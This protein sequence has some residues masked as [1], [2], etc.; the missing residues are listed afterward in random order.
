MPLH[1]TWMFLFLL[2]LL[3][4][5][6]RA[7]VVINEIFYH[8]PDDIEELAYIELHNTD[9]D[10]VD[11][12]GWEFTRGVKFKFPAGTEIDSGGF[13]VVCRNQARLKRFFGVT[14]AG[15]FES[16]LSAKG[17]RIELTDARG[18]KVDAVKYSDEAP[19]PLG[20]DGLSGS[21]ERITPEGGSDNPVNWAAS[22]LSAD[23][24]KPTGTPGR[25]NSCFSAEMPPVVSAVKAQPEHPAPNQPLAVDATVR[26]P[27]GVGSVKLLYLVAG[28]GFEKAETSIVMKD[29]GDGRYAA[30]VPGQAAGQLIRYRIEAVGI[31]GARR[32]S[33]AKSEPRPALSAYVHESVKA[34]K[35]PQA[36]IINTTADEF[37]A[38]QDR[39]AELARNAA[40]TRGFGGPPG[41][42]EDAKEP[43]TT[44][45]AFVYFDPA[46][47]KVEV[48]DFVEV[49]SRKGGQ[50]VHFAKGQHFR[51]MSTVN[52]SFENPASVMIEP[53][54]YELYRRAGMAAP[55]SG[56]LRL[57]VNG[58]P[59][60]YQLYVE[61]INRAFLRRN[62][63]NDEGNLYKLLW[64]GGGVTEQHDK[65]TNERKGHDDLLDL[66]E[67]LEK[68][69]GDAL[70]A[71]IRKQFDVEQVINYF[72]VNTLLSHWDGFFNNYFT[73]HDV[74]GTG[75]WTMYP[76]D[77]DQTWGVSMM[78]R[79]ED[80]AAMPLTFGMAGDA[81]P[82]GAGW[83]RPPGY[84]SGPLLANP[85][86]RKL[87]L[88]RTKQLLETVFNEK[89]LGPLLDE[90]AEK[91][92]PEI[93]LRAEIF[94]TDTARAERQHDQ[95]L[96]ALRQHIQKRG[97]FLL[98]QE[99]LK[100]A[101]PFSTDG[102]E[103][104]EKKKKEKAPKP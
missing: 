34:A 69:K 65:K 91:L 5:P 21:L 101:G 77:Q 37:H 64:F 40:R 85:T 35:V 26:D 92:R 68:N 4:A 95:Q 15:V 22:P 43:T 54:A 82:L 89:A 42:G 55:Q 88:A 31:G 48:Y 3:P 23:R 62:K 67:S 28:P 66:I 84:F 20:A 63:I 7:R 103:K 29:R 58:E 30:E 24:R 47:N 51:Q 83:W 78:G 36:W 61:Q 38:A 90:T 97:E 13:V 99:E 52:V 80:L 46:T 2:A 12:S 73:Y 25:T 102:L 14:A 98:A 6:L 76:W 79:S 72:A 104:P 56:H 75:R 17:E 57:W 27:K 41:R 8:A 93:K 53:L 74:E 59:A 70:W 11:L 45:S 1:R 32:M 49:E 18:R 87:Y 39:M 16:N 81:P 19:W 50:K 96:V 94:K 33:P 10:P 9:E 60:G 100:K 86:F 71:V 44:R